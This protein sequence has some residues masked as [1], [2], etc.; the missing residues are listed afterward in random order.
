MSKLKSFEQEVLKY[1][2]TL[3]T[4]GSGLIKEIEELDLF[5]PEFDTHKVTRVEVIDDYERK[6]L[7][8]AEDNKVILHLQ[9]GGRTLKVFI[10][11]KPKP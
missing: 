3:K 6:F 11:K 5:E 10:I 8:W 9:D 4:M 7:S 1:W 2:D